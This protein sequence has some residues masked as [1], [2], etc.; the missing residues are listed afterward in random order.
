MKKLV[1]CC[2]H[3]AFAATI[4]HAAVTG[5]GMSFV[6]DHNQI[7]EADP[8]PSDF[9]FFNSI[10]S[11]QDAADANSA[12]IAFPGGASD[13]MIYSP[14]ILFVYYSPVFSSAAGLFATYQPGNYAYTMTSGTLNGLSG[15]LNMPDSQLP[16]E[17]PRLNLGD[18]TSMQ[19]APANTALT[20][21]W[22]SFTY[23][24]NLPLHVINFTTV[25]RTEA[26]YS[27]GATGDNGVFNSTTIPAS[28]M[29]SGHRYFFYLEYEAYSVNNSGM[30]GA[31]GSVVALRRTLGYYNVKAEPGTIAGQMVLADSVRN[32][33]EDID[34]VVKDAANNT[35]SHTVKL[36][37]D[38][39]Y[40]F[41]TALTGNVNV[42]FKGRHWL[43]TVVSEIDT[44]IGQ[45]N[46]D[47]ILRNGDCDGSDLVNTD[48]YL[49]LNDHFDTTLGDAGYD[50]R[51]DL[52]DNYYVNTDDY[53]ILSNNFD[54]AGEELP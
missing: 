3:A 29:K 21:G 54:E 32:L 5:Y 41:D 52:D 25:D 37:Y 9:Y 36:G 53:L 22:P 48:D 47:P 45:D 31:S 8:L 2:L 20:V 49:I 6:G 23:G 12:T 33:G 43:T 4:S 27:F 17:A 34:I 40:A 19:D 11:T 24:G 50:K 30:G 46:I 15:T 16:V 10:L 1:T 26:L 28:Q 51:A 35:E 44:S 18:F 14:D 39:F 42:S 38:G 13:S 7:S